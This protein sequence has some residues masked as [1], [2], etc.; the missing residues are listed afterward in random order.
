[1]EDEY[2][3]SVAEIIAGWFPD[4]SGLGRPVPE[5]YVLMLRFSTPSSSSGW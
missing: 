4:A 5:A 3:L 1:M 2:G